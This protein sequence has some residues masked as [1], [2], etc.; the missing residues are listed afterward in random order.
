[1]IRITSQT[2]E[3]RTV[4]TIDGQMAES[5]LGEVRR[6]RKSLTGAVVLNLRGLDAC[7]AGGI[8]ALR[9]WLD[10]GATLQDATPFLA[11]VL[12]DPVAGGSGL[13][14]KSQ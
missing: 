7:A 13:P 3:N 2:E 1:M 6:V 11:M 8:R 4:V 10:A 14:S 12:E 5:D 9:D